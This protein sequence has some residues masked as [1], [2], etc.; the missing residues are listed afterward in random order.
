M[1][2]LVLSVLAKLANNRCAD[3]IHHK[4]LVYKFKLFKMIE[5]ESDEGNHKGTIYFAIAISVLMGFAL[6]FPSTIMHTGVAVFCL[7]FGDG[8]AALF[9]RCLR[10]ELCFVKQIVA[11]H[12][13]LF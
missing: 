9:E 6:L 11:G 13:S 1:A 12:N 3:N 8:F 5:R 10:S 4:L 7:C 2:F